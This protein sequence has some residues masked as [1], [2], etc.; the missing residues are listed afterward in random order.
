MV[1][2]KLRDE[3]LVEL[4]RRENQELYRE[5]V[6]RYQDKLLRY[7]HW[8][9]NDQDKAADV[10]QDAFI[11][12]FVNLKSFNTKKK[13][14]SWIYRIVH[15]EAINHLRKEKKKISLESNGWVREVASNEPTVEDKMVRKETKQ[16]INRC[17][18]R[19][20]L[21]YRSP[22]SLS[23]LEEKSYEEISDILRLPVGT[24]GTR[25]NRGKKLMR[26]VFLSDH[27]VEVSQK[28]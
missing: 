25:I 18:K 15:N 11:K 12:A 16:S 4:V 21:I 27:G 9:V 22:L 6:R 8:L 28:G 26:L 24:V 13:F 20:P 3:K 23:F 17:L 2:K 5:I 7:A 10:V 1:V 19:L 14:S